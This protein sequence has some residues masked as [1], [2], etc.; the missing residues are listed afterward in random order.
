MAE[1][2]ASDRLS[3]RPDMAAPVEATAHVKEASPEWQRFYEAVSRAARRDRAGLA[4]KPDESKK[5][6]KGGSD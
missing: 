4:G 5:V 2:E 6:D 3:R 1:R